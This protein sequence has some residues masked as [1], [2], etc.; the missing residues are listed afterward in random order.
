MKANVLFKYP[1]AETIQPVGE[2]MKQT[3]FQRSTNGQ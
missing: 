1:S 3:V 2:Q